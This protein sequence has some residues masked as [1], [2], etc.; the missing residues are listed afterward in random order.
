MNPLTPSFWLLIALF[1]LIAEF[2]S[3]TL[4][5]L[6]VSL[7]LAVVGALLALGAALVPALVTGS[8]AGI[9]GLA[10]LRR[11]KRR[12]SAR[13]TAIDDPDLGQ[14]VDIVAN[15]GGLGTVRYRGAEWQAEFDPVD[16]APGSRGTIAGRDDNRLKIVP[17]PQGPTP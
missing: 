6:V 3:G 9:V 5:L 12:R 15:R 11:F 13:S 2:F 14:L 17:Y 8:A 7:A 4:Y 16:L 1:A 10:L